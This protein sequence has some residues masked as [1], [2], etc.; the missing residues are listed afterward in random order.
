M[1]I[2][3]KKNHIWIFFFIFYNNLKSSF[4]FV[5]VTHDNGT[6]LICMPQENIM[7]SIIN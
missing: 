2:K 5:Y 6:I 4:F 3:I 7:S 1:W